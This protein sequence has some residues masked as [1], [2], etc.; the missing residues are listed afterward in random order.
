LRSTYQLSDSTSVFS[1]STWSCMEKGYRA[2]TCTVK[3]IR[4]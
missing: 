1:T 4:A 2:K 3:K